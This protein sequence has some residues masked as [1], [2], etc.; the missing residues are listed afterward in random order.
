M[1]TK[2]TGIIAL[3]IVLVLTTGVSVIRAQ[4]SVWNIG[5]RKLPASVD[6]SDEFREV[7][8]HTPTPD[9]AANLEIR[10]ETDKEWEEWVKSRD[11]ATSKFADQLAGLLSVK[12]EEE[13][14]NGVRVYHVKPAEIAEEHQKHLFV[15]IHGG[16]W[17]LNGG[18]AGNIEPI[19]IAS[20]LK[21]AVVSIDYRMPPKYPAPAA[22][23]DVIA[24]WK[25]LLKKRSPK[26]MV[27]GGSSGGANITLS[28]VHRFKEAGLPVPAALYAGTPAVDVDWTGDSRF[29]NEGIDKNLVAWKH[30][31]HDAGALYAG[32]Y[33]LKHPHVSPIYGDFTGFPPTYI[34]AGTRD[35]MLS[36]AVRG[37][38]ALRRAGVEADLHI[39]E[40]QS[41]A[42]YIGAMNSP[43]SIEHY[44]E[45]NTFVL[46]HLSSPLAPTSPEKEIKDVEVPKSV[47]F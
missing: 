43:E 21:M 13:R 40:G 22:T 16:A 8:L 23:D 27:M 10:L 38:R 7:L 46:E 41:H 28:S 14:I 6:V 9:V 34:I 19:L 3:V 18:N 33:D 25:E 2:Q 32:D 12:I 5:P 37:H 24:V 35:L 30:V 29:I 36:D 47:T 17:V 44:T 26:L 4:E 45:L 20:R 42:D 15:Y 39:Y 1:E 11:A 31:P